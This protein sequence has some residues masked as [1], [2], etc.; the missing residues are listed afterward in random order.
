MVRKEEPGEASVFVVA[1]DNVHFLFVVFGDGVHK[2]QHPNAIR[3]LANPVV[4]AFEDVE[5][6]VSKT[7]WLTSREPVVLKVA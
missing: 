5:I 1:I 7:N 3:L 4:F 6:L 2:E